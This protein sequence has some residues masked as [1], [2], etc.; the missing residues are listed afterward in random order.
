MMSKENIRDQILELL[1]HKALIG[2]QREM[3]Q[4]QR[5]NAI[6]IKEQSKPKIKTIGSMQEIKHRPQHF[7]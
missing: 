7:G 2:S 6:I 5:K 1:N 4:L 3:V